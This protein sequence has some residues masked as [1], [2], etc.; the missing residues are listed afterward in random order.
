VPEPD[1]QGRFA[2]INSGVS[3]Q[4]ALWHVRAALNVAALSCAHRP[5]GAGIVAH[6]NA[7]LTQ[8]KAVFATAY[9]AE[10]SRYGQAALDQH[11]TRLYNFFAQPPAQTAFCTAAAGVADRIAG[12]PATG[13]PQYAPGALDQLEA[14]IL[15]Y[16]RAYNAYRIA[17]AQ[18]NA[19]PKDARVAAAPPPPVKAEK[20]AAI[21]AAPTAQSWRIQLGAFTGHKAAEAAW[22]RARIRVPSLASYKPHYEDVPGGS[23]LV[24]LQVGSADDRAGAIRLCATAAAGGFDCL[25]VGGR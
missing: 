17:L 9:A 11:M 10:S 4:E 14:P 15:D 1:A 13:L 20:V 23:P 25:P 8:R 22:E 21:E 7:L 5:G 12:V 2:T 6:Y 18:W 3:A 24:R 16:Y 19:H